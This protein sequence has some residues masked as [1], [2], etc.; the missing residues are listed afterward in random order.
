MNKEDNEF[1]S[2]KYI[3]WETVCI[4]CVSKKTPPTQ[5]K[6]IWRPRKHDE[7]MRFG[8]KDSVAYLHWL[9]RAVHK[10]LRKFGERWR[11]NHMF[12]NMRA[13]RLPEKYV[14][15]MLKWMINQEGT[16]KKISRKNMYVWPNY[17]FTKLGHIPS[18]MILSYHFLKK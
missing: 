9:S 3:S 14:K 4:Q 16:N 5:I 10:V 13:N 11:N 17:G 1:L 18:N 8:W 15:L 6:S 12:Q 7:H 2:E